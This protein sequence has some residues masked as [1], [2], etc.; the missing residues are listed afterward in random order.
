MRVGLIHLR[1]K[2]RPTVMALGEN[3]NRIHVALLQGSNELLF[4]KP[5]TDA[6]DA[7]GRMKIKMD[8]T[9]R[10]HKIALPKRFFQFTMFANI[11]QVFSQK[12]SRISYDP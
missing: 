11:L 12:K 9:I 7:L 6:L 2:I 1:G 5:R 4:R 10:Q 8:L 3:G